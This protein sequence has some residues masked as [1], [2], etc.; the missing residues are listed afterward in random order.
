MTL[1]E[2]RI[3]GSGGSVSSDNTFV[4]DQK[5]SC[6][7][8]LFSFPDRKVVQAVH[9]NLRSAFGSNRLDRKAIISRH[10]LQ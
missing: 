7:T 9:L 10:I 8:S 6:D 2:L 1:I 3:L 5:F 4:I